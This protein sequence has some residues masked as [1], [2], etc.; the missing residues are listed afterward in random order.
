MRRRAMPR[1]ASRTPTTT[2]SPTRSSRLRAPIP[3]KAD[4]DGD[5]VSDG[6]EAKQGSDPRVADTDGDGIPD[7]EESERGTNPREA[8]SDGD[9]IDDKEE[10]ERG[11]NPR[12]ADTDGDGLSD[13]A[14]VEAGTD[15]FNKDSDGDGQL[16]GEDDD[17]TAYNAGLDDVAAGAVC[18]DATFW[19]CPDDDDP[20]RASLEYFSGQVLT[21]IFAVGDIRDFVAAIASGKWGD[22]AWSAAGVVP[23]AAT[24]RRSARRSAS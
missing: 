21:G 23:L 16:D 10:I 17:P 1:P 19:A 7:G 14:E 3:T 15:P 18:G 11:S 22:A 2:A 4:T 12:L 8:D 20:V 24:P 6:E 13:G 9:G 5:G